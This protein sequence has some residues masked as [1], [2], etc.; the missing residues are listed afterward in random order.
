MPVTVIYLGPPLPTA[1]SGL[2]AGSGEQP[3]DA[4]AARD[5]DRPGPLG[6]APGGVYLAARVTP[7]AG[8]LLP[9]RF[10]LTGAMAAPAVCSLWHCPAGHPG[11]ALPTTPPCGART[12]LGGTRARAPVPTRPSGQLVRAAQHMALAVLDF[13]H[14]VRRRGGATPDRA[15]PTGTDG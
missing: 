4:C 3:S 1:S 12:F 15:G 11:W 10:T 8:A 7:G 5:R 14:G 13:G 6:L 2:P 9:H